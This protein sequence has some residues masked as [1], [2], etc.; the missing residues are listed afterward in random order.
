MKYVAD[1]KKWWYKSQPYLEFLRTK[2]W[3]YVIGLAYLGFFFKIERLNITDF[4]YISVIA[5]LYVAHGYTINNYFDFKLR[6]IDHLN[7]FWK[8]INFQTA[9][10][11]SVLFGFINFCFSLFYSKTIF[12]LVI[13]GTAVSFIYSSSWTRF[14]DRFVLNIILNSTGFTIL[15]LIGY[16]ANKPF[17]NLI[18]FLSGYIWLGVIPS[19]IIHLMAHN[20][21]QID[22]AFKLFYLFLLLWLFEAFICFYIYTKLNILFVLTLVFCIAQVLIIEFSNCRKCKSIEKINNIRKIFK[23]TDII[24]GIFLIIYFLSQVK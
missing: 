6:E 4:I 3:F 5:L 7:K 13:L 14:K 9:L 1:I 17:S 18:I 20:D 16:L 12:T 24:L 22:H 23:I 10:F 11:I 15:F 21:I 8:N 2:D 19:Q